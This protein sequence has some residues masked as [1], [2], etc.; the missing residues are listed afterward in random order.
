MPR[1]HGRSH[2]SER[3][4]SS[5]RI[6]PALGVGFG[7]CAVL[8]VLYGGGTEQSG[9]AA[10]GAAGPLVNHEIRYEMPHAEEVYLGWGI[11]GWHAVPEELRPAGTKLYDGAMSTP[12]VRNGDS[13]VVKVR[14]PAGAL[15]NYG[16]WIGRARTG[17]T[18]GLWDGNGYPGWGYQTVAR[19]NGVAVT[20][21][22]L[23]FAKAKAFAASPPVPLITQKIRYRMAQAE[24]VSLLWGVN[25]WQPV[26]E[27][28]RPDP[29]TLGAD[30]IMST[31]MAK[32]EDAFVARVQVPFGATLDYDFLISKTRD[33]SSVSVRES[34]GTDH[35]RTVAKQYASTTITSR[36]PA[37][38]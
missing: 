2:R 1:L 16:F 19:V 25:G 12:M 13:F 5:P 6:V 17:E 34:T 23:N 28:L 7:V 10:S 21:G 11:N 24:E 4:R 36:L 26:P 35:F 22:T 3:V 33:G 31:R 38:R 27:E 8:A 20:I 30:G 32:D 14:V 29:T 18:V 9:P 15:I 37:I